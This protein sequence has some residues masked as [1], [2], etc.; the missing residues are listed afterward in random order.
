MLVGIGLDLIDLDHFRI[1][2]ED[3]D[4]ELLE[5]CFTAR[6]LLD[7]EEGTSR[8]GSLAARFAAKEAVFKALAGAKNISLTDIETIRGS[9][10]AL[11]VRFHGAAAT[12]VAA[13][14]IDRVLIT[15]SHSSSAAAAVAVALSGRPT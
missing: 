3:E 4:P 12:L 15:V 11:S 5:R 13:K 7:A 1:H 8:I 10:G 2:Y 6:E 9:D 14:G